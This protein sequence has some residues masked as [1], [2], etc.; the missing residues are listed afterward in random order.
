MEENKLSKLSILKNASLATFCSF[1]FAFISLLIFEWISRKYKYSFNYW[2]QIELSA[3]GALDALIF[4]SFHFILLIVGFYF[5]I[6]NFR[7]GNKKKL[8]IWPIIVF[9]S[10]IILPGLVPLPVMM[11]PLFILYLPEFWKGFLSLSFFVLI[12]SSAFYFQKNKYLLKAVG[13][14][15]L[16]LFILIPSGK[17]F[18]GESQEELAKKGDEVIREVKSL[19][20]EAIKTGNPELCE[21]IK[22][23][24]ETLDPRIEESWEALRRGF[25]LLRYDY[26]DPCIAEVAIK[27]GDESL[28]NK[29]GSIGGARA[30]GTREWCQRRVFIYNVDLCKEFLEEKAKENCL[31]NIAF[32]TNNAEICKKIF[33][34]D[35]AD[36]IAFRTKNPEACAGIGCVTKIALSTNNPDLCEK[37]KYDVERDRCFENFGKRTKNTDFCKKIK[38]EYIQADCII[39]IAISRND[40]SLCEL[41]NHWGYRKKDCYEKFR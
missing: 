5:G 22:E 3:N 26:Y 28:C 33:D 1:Y 27:T 4:F 25:F 37:E 34:F 35:C 38:N 19:K 8:F 17:Y 13:I 9:G 7:K 41:L 20:E 11:G 10:S 23:I 12:I 29:M 6:K 31:R 21:K 24:D 15:F 14:S 39:D 32:D 36:I 2:T 40:S 30:E 16:I 18:Y